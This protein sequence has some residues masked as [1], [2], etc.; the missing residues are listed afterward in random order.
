MSDSATSW[1][2]APLSMEFSRPEYW[3]RSPFP[4]PGVQCRCKNRGSGFWG[5]PV[6]KV[7]EEKVKLTQKYE[8]GQLMWEMERGCYNGS[9]EKKAF[10]IERG[11]LTVLLLKS[12]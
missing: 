11:E 9:Q 2:V 3:S 1:T 6:F 10:L 12:E 8:K 5:T 7:L 4:S